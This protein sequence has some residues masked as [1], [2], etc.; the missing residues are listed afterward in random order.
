M[1]YTTIPF[2]VKWLDQ[3]VVFSLDS[4]YAA[5]DKVLDKRHARGILYPLRPLLAIAILAQ[6]E[7]TGNANPF[8]P[9][10]S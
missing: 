5:L 4:L 1:Q 9:T 10:S 3:A 7:W 8:S 2:E 6:F